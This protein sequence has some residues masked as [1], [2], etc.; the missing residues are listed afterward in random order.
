MGRRSPQSFAKQ[1]KE[2]NRR[3]KK[4]EKA[5]R[6]ARRKEEY[7]SSD[8]QVEVAP[9]APQEALDTDEETAQTSSQR[10]PV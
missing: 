3:D 9:E 6:K 8:R 1:Q 5:K 4:K 2:A 7:S 10:R